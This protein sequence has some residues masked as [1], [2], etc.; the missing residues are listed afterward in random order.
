MSNSPKRKANGYYKAQFDKT[1]RNKL[2]KQKKIA[3]RLLKAKQK[4]E[5]NDN[6]KMRPL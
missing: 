4:H 6:L 5:R 3:R 2:R 1:E